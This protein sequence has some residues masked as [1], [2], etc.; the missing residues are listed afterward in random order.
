M[1]QDIQLLLGLYDMKTHYIRQILTEDQVTE[2]KQYLKNAEENNNWIDG[3]SSTHGM[4]KSIKN[5]F[6]ISDFEL[7]KKIND[8]IMFALDSDPNFLNF[9]AAKSTNVNIISRYESGDQYNTHIDDWGNGDYST[10]IFLSDPKTYIGGELCLYYGGLE[11]IKIKLDAG[12]AITYHTGTLHR[13]NRVVSGIRYASV[14]W[15]K[16]LISDPFIRN[17]Y[18]ELG[19]IQESLLN[20]DLSPIHHTD[21]MA[22]SRDPLLSINNLKTEILRRYSNV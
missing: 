16:S 22:V 9:T 15:T 5:N 21:C 13:V 11:E 8:K 1:E 7:S 6:E 14:F 4:S 19:N 12:W 2:V 10:T 20:F 3:V 18:S 17:I